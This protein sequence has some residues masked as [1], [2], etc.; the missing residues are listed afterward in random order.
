M[1]TISERIGAD[2]K[3]VWQA[4]V[5]K[6][7]APTISRTFDLKADAETWAREIEREH[8]RGN[9]A[10]LRQ[11]AVRTTI[12]DVLERYE[13][14]RLP[15]L[16][17]QATVR[18][19]LARIRERFG[20]FYIANIRGLEIS[21]WCDDLLKLGLSN[22]TVGHHLTSL[23]ALF[24]YMAKDLSIDLPGGN[25]CRLVRKPK[26]SDARD[27]RLRPGEYEAL[28][29]KRPDLLAFIILAIETSMRRGELV[30]LR[31]KHVDLERRTAHLPT[32]KN[33]ESRTVALSSLAVATLADLPRRS[34]GNV[35][36]WKTGDGFSS[37]WKR[38][39]AQAR[40]NYILGRV[41]DELIA[42][43]VDG[44]AQVRALVYHKREP[45]PATLALYKRI[46]ESDPFFTDLRFHDLR[47]EATSRLFE[48]GLGTMEVASMTGHKSLSMLTRYTHMD[49]AKLAQ[50]LG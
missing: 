46:E 27:R 1:A 49:A 2:G 39:R 13:S 20:A 11:D 14:D 22:T 37:V 18:G 6:K 40:R 30:N 3:R 10:V 4:K 17:S 24:T 32:S 23:S 47:H 8:Q 41:R 31:W 5:R 38:H 19:H 44:E 33:G 26:R 12:A 42:Q 21:R 25:P 9:I 16:R 50:K 15:Q 28:H 29:A 45:L 43:G 34:D 7:G 36:P 35:F 48:K